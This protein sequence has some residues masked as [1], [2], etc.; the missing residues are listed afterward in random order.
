MDHIEQRKRVHMED[1]LVVVCTDH[2][3]RFVIFEG[4]KSLFCSK[5]DEPF[6]DGDWGVH[7]TGNKPEHKQV[8]LML[9][10]NEVIP[11]EILPPPT[12]VD[13]K[14]T[15]LHHLLGREHNLEDLDGRSLL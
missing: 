14:P 1:W 12:V 2:G 11:R 3:G 4:E 8:F 13:I 9:H 6:E 5:L 10:G 15:I 7:S